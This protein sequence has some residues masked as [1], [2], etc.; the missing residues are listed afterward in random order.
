MWLYA[1]PRL[2]QQ[3]CVVWSSD[4]INPHL[5]EKRRNV[6]VSIFTRP[7]SLDTLLQAARTVAPCASPRLT[8]RLVTVLRACTFRSAVDIRT[9]RIRTPTQTEPILVVTT[10]GEEAA[11]PVGSVTT[12]L[13]T[14]S[15]IPISPIT[16]R[17]P[18]HP[19]DFVPQSQLACDILTAGGTHCCGVCKTAPFGT[20][21]HGPA[22]LHIH[23]S[24]GFPGGGYPG[25]GYPGGGY[26]GGGYPGGGFP[27]G[28]PSGG[29]GF[30]G[31]K[32]ANPSCFYR[33]HTDFQNNGGTH[34]CAVCKSAPYGTSGH[35]PACQHMRF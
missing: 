11:S 27:G 28:Y 6:N 33:T 7:Y 5:F 1:T 16:V 31:G 3:R 23:V 10:L 35:G 4:N 8:A 29:G 19:P 15:S 32:C 13:A 9:T 24:G 20:S 18:F 17:N 34:C 30:P 25:G 2:E 14:T 22:C 12:L 26:P 21:G